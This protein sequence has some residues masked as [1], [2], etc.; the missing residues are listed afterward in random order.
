MYCTMHDPG[1]LAKDVNFNNKSHTF[2]NNRFIK[3]YLHM[4]QAYLLDNQDG[5]IHIYIYHHHLN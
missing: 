1:K 3:K 2:Y 4:N 5:S